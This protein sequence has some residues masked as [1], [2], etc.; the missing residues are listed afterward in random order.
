[1]SLETTIWLTGIVIGVGM[2]AAYARSHDPLHPMMYLGP[3]L[4][5]VYFFYPA[6]LYYHELIVECF[7]D[8][9]DVSYAQLVNLLGV[10]AFVLGVLHF[11]ISP[12]VLRRR[13]QAL[14]TPVMLRRMRTTGWALGLF[15]L[16]VYFGN[17]WLK[18]G[19][20][21]VYATPKAY[22]G[23]VSGY[24]SSA[25]LL[26]IPAAMLYLMSRHERKAGLRDFLIVIVF[27]SPHLIHGVLGARRGPLFLAVVALF[28]GWFIS[29]AR[30]PS[31]H[32]AL[33][34]V[35]VAGLLALF[36]VSQ[37]QNIYLGSD[38]NFDREAYLQWISP[39]EANMGHTTPYSWGLILTSRDAHHHF[40]GRRYL[41][42]LL[43][44]P[45]PRQLWPRKYEA[46]GMGW[47]LT[48]SG[49]GGMDDESWLSSVGRLP[50]AGSAAGMVADSYLE[51]GLLGLVVCYLVGRIYAELWKR[52]VILHG[53]WS[54]IYLEACAV[55]IFVPSQGVVTAWLYRLLFLAVPT[56]VIWRLI[57]GRRRE[58]EPDEN[59]ALPPVEG[60]EPAGNGRVV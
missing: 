53:V 58:A 46:T 9:P 55:S 5:Y 36:V 21:H 10:S 26:T 25:P 45:I 50:Q 7:P 20:G 24:L 13:A 22:L 15:G 30:R 59:G 4:G 39:R 54:I 52:S 32:L 2:A 27:I 48:R 41:V 57:T 16:A 51:F 44:R 56:Y 49:S 34:G 1:V 23:A 28:F 33:G 40:W 29:R 42:Q 12:E 47:M 43:V 60:R 37:R 14:L 6:V 38:F 3:M 17:V 11:R 35:G 31:L 8:E 18:G 19:L